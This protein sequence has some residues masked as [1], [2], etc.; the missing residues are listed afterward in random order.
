MLRTFRILV[1][2]SL[3]ST[4]GGIAVQFSAVEQVSHDWKTLLEWHGDGGLFERLPDEVS[5]S[6]GGLVLG[7]FV[8]F[9]AFALVA[10]IGMLFFWPF[11]RL[12]FLVTTLIWTAMLPMMGLSVMLPIEG[13]LYGIATLCDGASLAMAYFSPISSRFSRVQT[14]S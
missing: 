10:Q 3:L 14:A 13:M 1:L 8:A 12:G 11:A 6:S 2:A 4:I 9:V 7:V 5:E